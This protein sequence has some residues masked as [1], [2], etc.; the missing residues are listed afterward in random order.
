MRGSIREPRRHANAAPAP[1]D[2]RRMCSS[3]LTVGVA[4]M[5]PRD[6]GGESAQFEIRLLGPVG[7]SHRGRPLELGGVQARSVLAVLMLHPGQVVPRSV[8]ARNAWRGDP[9]DTAHGLITDYVSRLRAALA[10]AAAH[11]S[12][13]AVRPGFRATIEP[14][15]IDAHRF[16]ALLHQADQER[17]AHEDELAVAHLQ[18][19][20]ALWHGRTLAL[21]DV[22]AD[23][24]RAQAEALQDKRLDALEQLAGAYQRAGEPDR[25]VELLRHE[26]PRH[27]HRDT[28]VALLVRALTATGQGA[29]AVET[30]DRAIDALDQAGLPVGRQVQE[31][32]REAQRPK[33]GQG[34]PS[35]LRQLPP[36]TGAFTGRERELAELLDLAGTGPGDGTRTTVICAV[37]GMAGIGKT[38]LVIH[39]AHRL[40]DRYPDGQLFIDLHGFTEGLAPRSAADVLADTL[41]TL[42]V[43]PQLIPQ[44]LDAR[45]ALYRD[46]LAGK[47]LLVVL[48]NARGEQQIRPLLPGHSDSLV[49]VTSRVRLKGL[50]D[51][52]VLSL[53]VLSSADAAALLRRVAGPGRIPGG[54]PVLAH[55]AALCGHLPL[56]LRIAGAL[57]RNRPSWTLQ[58]LAEQLD[59]QRTRLA[60]LNDRDRDLA[61]IFALSYAA[62]DDDRQSL[63]R[64]L[65][66]HPGP[67]ID[68]YATAALLAATPAGADHL[69]QDLV[70]QNLLSEHAFGRYRMHD[71]VRAHARALCA[72][73]DPEGERGEASTRLFEYYEHTGYRASH[74]SSRQPRRGPVG[75]AP[76]HGPAL[77]DPSGSVTWLR[78]ERAN[79]EAAFDDAAERGWDGHVVAFGAALAALLITDGPWP[80]A[81]AVHEAAALA[82]HRIGD[83]AREANALT[84]LA[85]AKFLTRDFSA[86][87]D[88]VAQALELY[89]GI[90]DRRG[91]AYALTELGRARLLTGKRPAA[92]EAYSQAQE[93]HGDVGD[94]RGQTDALTELGR[95]KFLSADYAGAAADYSRALEYYRELG[96][97][98]GQT[99]LLAELG[100]L[101]ALTGDYAGAM[102]AHTYVLQTYRALGNRIGQADALA[103]LGRVRHA[104]G[105]SP[106]ALAALTEALEI[107]RDMHFPYGQA[108]ALIELGRIRR[109]TGDLQ[110]AVDTLG[111]ALQMCRDLG[112]RSG[113]SG[114]LAEYAAA[115]A[116]QKDQVRA[117]A[118]FQDALEMSRELEDPDGEAHS[119]EGVGE[120]L[121]DTGRLGEGVEHLRQALGLFRRLGMR[122][123]AERVE[124]RLANVHG[125][126]D[127]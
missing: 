65:G 22:E 98:L 117:L 96:D 10:P 107:F 103:G 2:G 9:P 69:L 74:A 76:A 8:I 36:D 56:A 97:G 67:D 33:P 23:W 29:L 41:R 1:P 4:S 84:D 17:A 6:D 61:A 108:H 105:D 63:Y 121:I 83:V 80:R 85:R 112:S 51:A 40:A 39:A 115:I 64:R 91:E 59:D 68:S 44:D 88:V 111:Q 26:A 13:D 32:R 31:A 125:S 77:D 104:T 86:A 5:A 66:L 72:A 58:R 34:T 106:G 11:V 42:G 62:L 15:M 54:D 123:D 99:H 110:G 81:V 20:L 127:R 30:A 82:A 3:G 12:L 113:E 90:G 57:I 45:A 47:R 116:A 118:L 43:H 18:H 53:D 70:D 7:A 52:H 73:V 122:P 50:D 94:R 102:D 89:R 25:A 95:A 14:G 55:V 35:P 126:A 48:D 16:S 119:R 109:L 27:P 46:R 37:D 28:L 79:L 78:G 124:A 100:R 71:L 19:A 75:P 87:G 49:L 101:K 38:A 21:E 92:I 120:C 60:A 93:A 114:A 24:L